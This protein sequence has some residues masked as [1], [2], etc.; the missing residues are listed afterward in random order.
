MNNSHC[1][2]G[3]GCQLTPPASDSETGEAA[4]TALHMAKF[5]DSDSSGE[6]DSTG[7]ITVMRWFYW[8]YRRDLR[9]RGEDSSPVMAARQS[10]SASCRRRQTMVG[11]TE[12]SVSYMRSPRC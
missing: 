12:H 4:S 2:V 8:C 10:S 1:R 7:V 9:P 3:P 5:T 11:S 6:M